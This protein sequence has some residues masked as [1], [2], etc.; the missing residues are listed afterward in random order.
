MLAPAHN[1]KRP[2]LPQARSSAVSPVM[3]SVA[4]VRQEPLLGPQLAVWQDTQSRSKRSNI[5]LKLA[6]QCHCEPAKRLGAA[7]Q[8]L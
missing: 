1:V 6:H 2:V 7:I 8:L 3:Q 5:G 4:V